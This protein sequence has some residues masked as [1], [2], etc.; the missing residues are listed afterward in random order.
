MVLKTIDAHVSGAPLRLIVDGFPPPRGRTMEEKRAWAERHADAVRRVAILEPRGRNDLRG[1][2]LT[3]PVSPG[4]HAGVLFMDADGYRALSGHGIVAVATI[5]LERGL[6]L[7][8]GD[9]RSLVLDT[10]AGTVRVTVEWDEGTDDGGM[11]DPERSR[12]V[13]LVRYTGVPSF[14]LHGGLEVKLPAR[15]V[16]ADVAFGG[17]FYAIVDS[18]AIG[19]PLDPDHAPELSRAGVAIARAVDAAHRVIHPTQPA[20]DVVRGTI[21][22]G[23]AQRASADLRSVAVL[24]GGGLN[25]SP[26]GTGL[27]AIM[28]VLGA[29]DLM[30]EETAFTPESLIG[31]TLRGR[32]GRRTVVGEHGAIVPEIEGEAWITGEHVLIVG[33]GDPLRDGVRVG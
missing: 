11:D 3:E 24:P 33:D 9:G 20:F 32:I 8:G 14:V 28:A 22:T 16:R 6:V 26:S 17:E 4:A 7:P 31:T 2:V 13:R 21:F 25:R 15:V 19:V 5:A 1:A 29:M 12:R 27:A 23:P 30:G 10:P 18:E